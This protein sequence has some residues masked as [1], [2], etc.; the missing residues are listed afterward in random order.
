MKILQVDGAFLRLALLLFEHARRAFRQLAFP[1]RD[2]VGMDVEMLHKLGQ[3]FLARDRGQRQLGPEC[4]RMRPGASL[5]QPM[6]LI[7]RESLRRRQAENPLRL[8][9]EFPGPALKWL[10]PTVE[11]SQPPGQSEGLLL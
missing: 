8:L 6:L 4:R 2:L 3:R 11:D 7:R 5:R 1:G 10:A 9:S